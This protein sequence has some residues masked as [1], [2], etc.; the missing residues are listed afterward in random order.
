MNS[1]FDLVGHYDAL[2]RDGPGGSGWRP[3][4]V[5]AFYCGC[6]VFEFV[7]CHNPD[8]PVVPLD[9]GGDMEE[10]VPVPSLAARLEMWLSGQQPW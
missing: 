7:D 8:G 3:G 2:R 6:S 5:P 4:M 1:E 10:S 9:L